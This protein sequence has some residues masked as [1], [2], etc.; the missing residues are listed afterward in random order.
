MPYDYLI[1]LL[2]A[3]LDK[4]GVSVSNFDFFLTQFV[5]RDIPIASPSDETVTSR[6]W[7]MVAWLDISFCGNHEAA[8]DAW[9][10]DV[11]SVRNF[12]SHGYV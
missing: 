2:V 12:A 9:R 1:P 11:C 5:D 3:A 8:Q 7:S 6:H 10:L 4:T